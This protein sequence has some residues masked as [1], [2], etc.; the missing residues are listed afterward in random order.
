LISDDGSVVVGTATSPGNNIR[1]FRWSNGVMVDLGTL[2]GSI[3][4]Q[5]AISSSGAVIVGRSFTAGNATWRAVRWAGGILTD[6]GTLGGSHSIARV[7][8]SDGSVVAGDSAVA[9]DVDYHAFRWE[10]G[11]MTDLG[12]LGGTEAQ[13]TGISSDGSVVVGSSL[14]AGDAAYHAFRWQGGAMTDLG[15]LGGTNSYAQAVSSNGSVV[16]GTSDTT[17]DAGQ[18]AY[19]WEAG[20]MV[21][22]G[23]LGGTVSEATAL[24]RDGSV[25]IGNS[26]T[27]GNASFKAFRWEGGHMVDLGTLGGTN[28]TAN[29]LS[30][31]GSVIVGYSNTSSSAIHAFRWTARS[32]MQDLNTLMTNGGVDMS[33]I[34]LTRAYDIT[35]DGQFI[36]GLAVIGTEQRGYVLRYVDGVGGGMT[37]RQSVQS[38]LDNLAKDQ[39]GA[40]AQ[41]HGLIAPLLGADKPIEETNEAGVFAAG[42]SITSGGFA[43]VSTGSG[44]SILGG[45]AYAE[46]DYG[47]AEVKH[48]VTGAVAM[49]Y[50]GQP[51]TPALQPV[52]EGGG[53][54]TRNADFEFART[55][56]NGAGTATGRGTT[57]GDLSYVY[58][59]LGMLFT[60]GAG[61]QIFASAEVGRE[62]MKFDAYS[63]T[64]SSAN[65]FEA[66]ISAGTNTLEL[67]KLRLA[68]SHRYSSLLDS[69][70]WVAGVW[71]LNYAN[72]ITATVPG[73]GTLSAL[74]PSDDA[75]LEYG[76]RVGF[77]LSRD[78]TLDSF[79][80][81]VSGTDGIDTRLHG[82]GAL[83]FQF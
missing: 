52:L 38:S 72:Q 14:I 5:Y 11:V 28:S 79:V 29:A 1:A 27:A 31:D 39:R 9:G 61:D 73:F 80:T 24:T 75:W 64:F 37:T 69:T 48:G 81:G 56:G 23:N 78:I 3:T 82:G 20:S 59:R 70:V 43:R 8:S 12:T 67:M 51:L 42:G 10:N 22:L 60:Y 65:P 83:R 44:F 35:P 77:K 7:V 17:G 40:M 21:A 58:A 13:S 62:R 54:I 63:E 32:G 4:H 49:R 47:D 45:L 36:V 2:G 53:W 68:W 25:I 19:R 50:V 71:D 74:S 76:G 34:V 15:T 16:V 18:H 66:H 33:G 57:E 6:L 55:Y 46:E 30:R 41:Q 26:A